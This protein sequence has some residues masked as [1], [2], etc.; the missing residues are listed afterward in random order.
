MVMLN[1]DDD[2]DD[3]DDEDG[4]DDD[5]GID[6]LEISRQ[7]MGIASSMIPCLALLATAFAP[8][9]TFPSA[10][11]CLKTGAPYMLYLHRKPASSKKIITIVMIIIM[12]II[13]THQT[14][15]H[16]TIHHQRHNY[17]HH[18]HHHHH[19]YYYYH[20]RS[21]PAGIFSIRLNLSITCPMNSLFAGSLSH[22]LT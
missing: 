21:V 22:T 4:C 17:Y 7:M 5:E 8:F 11:S 10:L 15:S 13:I 14:S 19:H 2:D 3:V 20:C 9:F 6:I 16:I 18:T 12:I 1:D